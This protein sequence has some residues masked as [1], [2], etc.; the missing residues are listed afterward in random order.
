MD[1]KG[2]IITTASL[3]AALVTLGGLTYTFGDKTG[4][5]PIIKKEFVGFIEGEFKVAMD[6]TEQNTLAI[7]HSRFNILFDK[8]RINKEPLT[9]DEKISLCKDALILKYEVI[10]AN[11]QPYCKDGKSIL[12]LKE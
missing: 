5:R 10:D 8:K 7:A 3:V 2:K 6:Q 4:W 12:M 9:M 11:G 1:I